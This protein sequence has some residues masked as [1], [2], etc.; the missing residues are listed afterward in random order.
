MKNDV[1]A[2][3]CD[4]IELAVSTEVRDRNGLVL[5]TS[6]FKDAR[7]YP[8]QVDQIKGLAYV[9]V[10]AHLTPG[11]C[12]AADETIDGTLI[13]NILSPPFWSFGSTSVM[14]P[15]FYALR[16]KTAFEWN[17]PGTPFNAVVVC[18][19]KLV[20]ANERMEQAVWDKHGVRVVWT[21]SQSAERLTL[22]RMLDNLK[23]S[24]EISSVPTADEIRQ[25]ASA[26]D[27][28]LINLMSN[29]GNYD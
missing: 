21:K 9:F 26:I 29:Q 5:S 28:N 14:S 3:D 13:P 4:V 15:V 19:E 17:Q 6:H 25:I 22:K 8:Y 1:N 12:L 16:L 11:K 10:I 2:V 24:A 27:L 18:P 23:S 7:L 20:V